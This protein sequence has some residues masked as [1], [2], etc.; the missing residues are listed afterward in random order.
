[1]APDVIML[2][3]D[4]AGLSPRF[5]V[6]TRDHLGRRS[7]ADWLA[8]PMNRGRLECPLLVVDIRRTSRS[9]R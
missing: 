5:F 6:R 2:A 7:G 3:R 1:M 8:T 9:V 4:S